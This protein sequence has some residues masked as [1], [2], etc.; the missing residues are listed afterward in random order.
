MLLNK[1]LTEKVFFR[2]N[3]LPV[4]RYFNRYG[5]YEGRKFYPSLSRKFQS[6]LPVFY[7]QIFG[8]AKHFSKEPLSISNH[9]GF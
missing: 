6:A 5:R 8:H 4:F 9:Q 1:V 3:V 2:V 7:S